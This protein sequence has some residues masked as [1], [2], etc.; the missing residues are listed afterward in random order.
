M[1]YFG[2]WF[3]LWIFVIPYLLRDKNEDYDPELDCFDPG[4]WD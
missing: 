1:I 4:R 2:C 3:F